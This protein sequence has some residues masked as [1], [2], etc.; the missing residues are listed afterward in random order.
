M[1]RVITLFYLVNFVQAWI[2][3]RV[4]SDVCR[5][6]ALFASKPKVEEGEQTNPCWEDL[7]DD[8]CAMSNVYSASFVASEWIKSMPCASGVA[9]SGEIST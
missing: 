9:V 1:K 8:D 4:R 2:N 7:Y 3:S 5:S 6:S